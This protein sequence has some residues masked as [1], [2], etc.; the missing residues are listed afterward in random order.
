MKRTKNAITA[1]DVSKEFFLLEKAGILGL[2]TGRH[3]LP[4]HKALSDINLTVPKGEIVGVLGHNGAGKSTLLRTIG[5]IYAPSAGRVEIRG[6]V[7]AIFELGVA[8]NEFLTG[9]EYAARSFDQMAGDGDVLATFID[10]VAE[11]AELGEHFEMPVRTYSAGMKAR[12]FF[13]V[14]TGFR[15]SIFLVDEVLSVGDSYFRARCWRRMREFK[16]RGI[17]GVFATHDWAAVLKLCEHCCVLDHG[18]MIMSGSSYAVVRQYLGFEPLTKRYDAWFSEDM[19]TVF[20]GRSNE[21]VTLRFPVEAQERTQVGFGV[22]LELTHPNVGWEN[23]MLLDPQETQ[24]EKGRNV[25]TVRIP[26]APLAPGHYLLHVFML[27]RAPDTGAV[28]EVDGRTWYHG[29]ALSLDIAGP[30]GQG[31]ARFQPRMRVTRH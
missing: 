3:G 30:E 9:R 19:P 4:S 11:F 6:D 20:Q 8:S 21:E 10:E 25:V 31:V 23:V 26:A 22:S 5:E 15:K 7:S 17:S 27:R 2:L 16:R 1:K 28:I 24:L 13:A 18:K 29:N 12:L 14:A